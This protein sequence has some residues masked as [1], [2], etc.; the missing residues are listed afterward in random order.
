VPP[1]LLLGVDQ[2]PIPAHLE[3]TTTRGDE[4]DVGVGELLSDPGLQTGGTGE[5]VSE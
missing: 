5:V 2:L 4:F 3:D 1:S